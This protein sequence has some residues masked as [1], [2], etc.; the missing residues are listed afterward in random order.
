M[1]LNY[2]RLLRYNTKTQ[3]IK[4]TKKIDKLDLIKIKT[5]HGNNKKVKR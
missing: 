2:V 1:S 5:F 3:V 4:K